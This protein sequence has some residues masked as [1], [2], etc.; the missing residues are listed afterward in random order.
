MQESWLAWSYKVCGAEVLYERSIERVNA[1]QLRNPNP[2]D[3]GLAYILALQ[4]NEEEF[5]ELFEQ[6]VAE[7]IPFVLFA[8]LFTIDY[9]GFDITTRLAGNERFQLLIDE[10]GFPATE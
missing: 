2:Y 7:G 10:L 4:G 1:A 6:I 3:P 9:L 5:V 8:K